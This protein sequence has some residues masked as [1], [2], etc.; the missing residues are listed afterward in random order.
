MVKQVQEAIC[1]LLGQARPCSQNHSSGWA[2]SALTELSSAQKHQISINTSLDFVVLKCSIPNL[3]VSVANLSFIKKL[4]KWV[5]L[6]LM[7]ECSTIFQ[8]ALNIVHHSVLPTDV[9]QHAQHWWLHNQSYLSALDNVEDALCL[10]YQKLSQ[11]GIIPYIKIDK[12]TGEVAQWWG[13]A[14]QAQGAESVSSSAVGMWGCKFAFFFIL[15]AKI[16]WIPNN[17]FKTVFIIYC[18]LLLEPYAYCMYQHTQGR[19]RVT[20]GKS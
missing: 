7:S 1:H 16:I 18:K 14:Q 2:L 4:L 13:T 10:Q 12:Q 17:C 6:A 11:D 3:A 8:R 5:L 20:S 19:W 15:N 9:K